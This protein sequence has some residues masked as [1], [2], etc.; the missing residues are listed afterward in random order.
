MSIQPTHEAKAMESAPIAKQ[1][2][3]RQSQLHPGIEELDP[4]SIS[5]SIYSQ[6]Y[7]NF[8]NV[9]DAGTVAEGD[10]ISI[11]LHNTA[12]GFAEAISSAVGGGDSEGGVLIDY[13]KRTGGNMTGAFRANHGFEAGV[14]NHR[15]LATIADGVELYGNLYVGGE[16]F[17]LG[18]RRVLSYD[19][20]KGVALVDAPIVDFGAASLRSEGDFVFGKDRANGVYISSTAVQIEGNDVYHKGNANLSTVDWI[21]KNGA[22]E[23][24][25]TVKGAATLSGELKALQGFQL[26]VNGKTLLTASADTIS[27][28]GF[29]SFGIGYGIKIGSI[30]VLVRVNDG[31]IQ[32][33]SSGAD[34]LLGSEQTHKI[35]LFSGLCDIDGDNTLIS[36]YGDAHFP[37]S[38]RVRHNY[39][40]DL[41]TSYRTS[42]IDEGVIIHKRLRFGSSNGSVLSGDDN[43]VTL[44]SLL[45]NT[46]F[47]HRP[48]TSLYKPLDR[49]SISATITSDA[50]FITFGKP[51]EG[52]GHIGIDGSHTRLTAKTLYFTPAIYIQSIDGGIKHYGNAIFADNLSS[53]R[54]ASGFAGYGWSILHNRTT[55]NTSATFDKLTIRKKMHIY[56]LEVQKNTATNGALWV[57]DS[58][59]GDMVYLLN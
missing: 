4:N 21:M 9:Q 34:L 33:S 30:P 1:K 41:L 2:G 8:F 23:G 55:G 38:L 14:G 16:S 32:L 5:Y 20:V 40:D 51:I 3:G 44:S 24:A 10:G 18:G 19:N 53:D 31:D 43:G 48:S 37:A 22:V 47:S 36:K 17:H 57:S 58:C 35:R 12:F 59:S 29:L 25:L 28:N 39:G 50:D 6:L 52:V 42:N 13:I 46:T 11:R 56:E 15:L 49:E 45:Q 27:A 54:F 26:G 7:S